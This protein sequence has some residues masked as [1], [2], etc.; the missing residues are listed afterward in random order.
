MTFICRKCDIFRVTFIVDSFQPVSTVVAGAPGPEQSQSYIGRVY[1]QIFYVISF[2]C[3]FIK[4]QSLFV[5]QCVYLFYKLEARLSQNLLDQPRYK[6]PSRL[7]HQS[8]FA[9]RQA[10]YVR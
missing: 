7:V 10:A 4:K 5:Q 2:Q 3:Q 6:T 1:L 8:R 9:R